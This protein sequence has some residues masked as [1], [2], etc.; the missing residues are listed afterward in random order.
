MDARLIDLP[1][2]TQKA[3]P[4]SSPKVPHRMPL[5]HTEWGAV[6]RQLVELEERA[7]KRLETVN[8]EIQYLETVRGLVM[9]GRRSEPSA[10]RRSVAVLFRRNDGKRDRDEVPFVGYLSECR[11]QRGEAATRSFTPFRQAGLFMSIN[12]PAVRVAPLS[13]SA[14]EKERQEVEYMFPSC[15]PIGVVK[16]KHFPLATA[17]RLLESL[18]AAGLD[19]RDF[20][21]SGTSARRCLS[22]HTSPE[23]SDVE[24]LCATVP[25]ELVRAL[26][27][28][29][30]GD[31][32]AI[33]S[34]LYT[35][36]AEQATLR[37]LVLPE[38][39]VHSVKL[40]RLPPSRQQLL[41]DTT[42]WT[43]RQCCDCCDRDLMENLHVQWCRVLQSTA[44]ASRARTVLQRKAY[45]TA[46]S[47]LFQ[48]LS[49]ASSVRQG[50][51][52]LVLA[53]C[54]DFLDL[55]EAGKL[56][57]QRPHDYFVFRGTLATPRGGQP[58]PRRAA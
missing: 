46:Y 2:V 19:E 20:A 11:T 42:M 6:L 57:L 47:Q 8:V 48:R 23:P 40:L 25:E 10:R 52:V 28:D 39:R 58:S 37:A 15:P 32:G 27:R 54:G 36:L 43:L 12:N 14:D 1:E 9:S 22:I 17:A 56:P 24:A 4:S 3:A 30:M 16:A 13:L 38:M 34:S 29:S 35:K 18:T 21:L 50:Y 33:A 51:L 41:L 55:V 5:Q 45:A 26:C 53:V 31:C 7:Q 49:A 44:P